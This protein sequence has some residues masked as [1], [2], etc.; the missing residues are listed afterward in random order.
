MSKVG[1]AQCSW[2]WS[3]YNITTFILNIS[4]PRLLVLYLTNWHP[5]ILGAQP[6]FWCSSP[7]G[8]LQSNLSQCRL[9]SGYCKRLLARLYQE[10]GLINPPLWP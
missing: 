3:G 7:P 9:Q 4:L 10:G 1:G 5:P 6:L 8:S 2:T